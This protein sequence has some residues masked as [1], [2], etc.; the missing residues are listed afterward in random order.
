L[1]KEEKHWASSISESAKEF[2]WD[3][4]KILMYLENTS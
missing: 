3:Y 2:G 1:K 4:E